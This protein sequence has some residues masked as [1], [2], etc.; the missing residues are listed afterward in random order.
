MKMLKK[1]IIIL[2]TIFI[3]VV[4]NVYAEEFDFDKQYNNM[5]K[6]SGADKLIDIVPED[7]K[8]ILEDNNINSVDSTLLT[9]LSIIDFIGGIISDV[10]LYIKRPINLLSIGLG[11]ILICAL[12]NS[13]GSG[14]NNKAYEQVFSVMC[15]VS[16]ATTIITPISEL[17]IKT[18]ELIQAISNFMLGFIP[19]YIGIIT[20]SGKPLS[21]T[22]YSSSLVVAIQVVSRIAATVLIP[23]LAVYMAFCIIGSISKKLNIEGIAKSI[24]NIAIGILTFMLTIFVGLFSMQGMVAGS[25][26]TVGLRA[27]KLAFSTFLPVVGSAI[28]DALSSVTGCIGVIKSTVGGFGIITVIASFLPIIIEVIMFLGALSLI[29]AFGDMFKTEH[30]S[31][32][33]KSASTML[34]LLL[35]ILVVFFMLIIISVTIMMTMTNGA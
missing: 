26:D 19:V 23:M 11:I 27:T 25:A 9:N 29:S 35:G 8:G 17:I 5:L 2:S 14:F 33:A 22:A 13:F 4:P 7:S 1:Y 20:V 10:N 34:S 32:I 31:S 15:V 30:I 28:G 18:S 3:F 24:K 16:L 21:A 12:L 6:S